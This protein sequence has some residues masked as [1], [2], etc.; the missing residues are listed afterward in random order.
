MDL[1]P[2]KGQIVKAPLIYESPVNIECIVKNIIPL[3]SHDMF[4]AEVVAVNADELLMDK[5][6]K[7][8]QLEKSNLISYSHGQY[9]VLGKR[10]GK[11]GFSVEKKK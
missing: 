10:V 3:G 4:I 11:F 7:I 9:Y 6:N 1:T 8:L 2:V 5:N